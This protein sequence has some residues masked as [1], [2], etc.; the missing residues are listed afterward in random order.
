[1]YESK[2]TTSAIIAFYQ[3]PNNTGIKPLTWNR[4][5]VPFPSFV[6]KALLYLETLKI[7][8]H[9]IIKR[10]GAPPPRRA[11]GR[12]C[13]R[14]VR[15]SPAPRRPHSNS[16]RSRTAAA[17]PDPPAR[18]PGRSAAPAARPRPVGRSSCRPTPARLLREPLLARRPRL[19]PGGS[20]A[21]AAAGRP[22]GMVRGP[23][24]RRQEV[25][26]TS[27]RSAPRCGRGCG[28]RAAGPREAGR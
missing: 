6:L 19:P 15:A 2:R 17:S 24:F 7:S 22:G 13:P 20:R 4:T 5:N 3:P 8:G 27:P 10:S 26:P 18:P 1:M 12:S 21:S 25:W 16:L 9:M 14:L 28:G 11:G 23:G